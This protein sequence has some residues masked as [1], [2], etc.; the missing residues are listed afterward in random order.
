MG[1]DKSTHWKGKY[2]DIAFSIV[3]FHNEYLGEGWCYY[4]FLP[5]PQLP[6]RIRERFWLEG[7]KQENSSFVYYNYYGEPLMSD[8]HWH[9]GITW[10]SKEAGYDGETRCVKL[11][12]D[13]QHLWDEGRYYNIDIVES[14]AKKT[15]DSLHDAITDMLTRC[16]YCGVYFTNESEDNSYCENCPPKEE[17]E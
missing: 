10:Y 15:I 3:S 8:L 12:C 9:G 13:Y 16:S 14:G 17:T 11:G 6:E 5:L 2:R 1:L 7:E 4:I